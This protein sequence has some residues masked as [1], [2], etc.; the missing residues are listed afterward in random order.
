MSDLR[1]NL[2]SVSSITDH[3]YEVGFRKKD[4]LVVDKNSSTVFRANRVGDLYYVESVKANGNGI[5]AKNERNIAM[6]VIHG[7]NEIDS[8]HYKLGHINERDMRSMEQS[9]DVYGIN[10]PSDGKTS[11]CEVCIREKQTRRPFPKSNGGRTKELLEIVHSD[12]CGPMR[13]GL[14]RGPGISSR[15]LMISLGGV[16][17]IL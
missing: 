11:Q 13:V 14:I 2:L 7:K 4:A 8:W 16:R 10:F 5:K 3:G 1:T 9:S 6:S 17:Y 15:S 12:V